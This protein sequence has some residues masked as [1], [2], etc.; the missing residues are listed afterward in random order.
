MPKVLDGTFANG[1]L[2]LVVNSSRL[3]AA[4]ARGFKEECAALWQ[5]TVDRVT[6]DLAAVEFVDSSGVGALLSGYKRMSGETA[7]V[8]LKR[9]RPPVQAVLELLRLHRIFDIQS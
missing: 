2:D 6:I 5:P 4:A 9:A 8:K 1:A 3:D 7:K